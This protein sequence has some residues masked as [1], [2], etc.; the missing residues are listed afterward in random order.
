M[1]NKTASTASKIYYS[2]ALTLKEACEREYN[3]ACSVIIA[4]S[5][6]LG[7]S[8][9][10]LR[11]KLLTAVVARYTQAVSKWREETIGKAEASLLKRNKKTTPQSKVNT[12]P[13]L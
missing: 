5:D 12:L 6:D 11:A 9:K 13:R 2:A 3:H 4:T 8:S 1:D 10:Q 7:Y